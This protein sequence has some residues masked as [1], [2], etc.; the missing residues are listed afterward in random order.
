MEILSFAAT[1]M[2][3]DDLT[4]SWISQRQKY[5]TWSHIY[6]ESKKVK[7]REAER[8]TVVTKAGRRG[9]GEILWEVNVSWSLTC[10]MV[11][12]VNNK[13][14]TVH[15][16]F[17]KWIDVRCSHHK[18]LI[19]EERNMLINFTIVIISS[20]MCLSKHLVGV[21]WWLNEWRIQYC[22]CCGSGCCYGAGS[23][24]AP[25]TS[26][27]RGCGQPPPPKKKSCYTPYMYIYTIVILK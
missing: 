6:V 8:R 24:P 9:N 12:I 10:G 18:K 13:Y 15:G 19:D 3:L 23:I 14:S 1:L 17:A 20:C 21:P 26:A 16:K 27:W 5:S 2:N 25:E 11:T 7:H 22:H 4:L